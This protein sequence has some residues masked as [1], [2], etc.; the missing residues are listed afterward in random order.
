[1]HAHMQ[2]AL[3]I[4]KKYDPE[5]QNI[6]NDEEPKKDRLDRYHQPRLIRRCNKKKS[7]LLRTIQTG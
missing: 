5:K 6:R 3:E 4:E 2:R 7:M 1:M